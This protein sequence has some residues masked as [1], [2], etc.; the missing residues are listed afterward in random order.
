VLKVQAALLDLGF[1]LPTRGADGVFGD[2]TGQAVTAFKQANGIEPSDP[3]VGPR[4][5]ARLDELLA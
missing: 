2:E 3:V 5:M 4:T 1:A